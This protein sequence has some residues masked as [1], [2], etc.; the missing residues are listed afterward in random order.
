MHRQTDKQTNILQTFYTRHRGQ[1]KWQDILFL[2]YIHPYNINS[3]ICSGGYVLVLTDYQESLNII[4]TNVFQ[5]YKLI[6]T[7][8]D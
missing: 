4:E 3:T 7:C 8:P 6:G 5:L 2:V 1:T